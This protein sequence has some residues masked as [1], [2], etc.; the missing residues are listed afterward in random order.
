MPVPF[1]ASRAIYPNH[2]SREGA[3]SAKFDPWRFELIL[4]AKMYCC[5]QPANP[6][7]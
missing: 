6:Y 2:V 5:F 4:I 1:A 3:K 7:G